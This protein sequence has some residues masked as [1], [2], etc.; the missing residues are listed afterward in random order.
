M[1]EDPVEEPEVFNEGGTKFTVFPIYFVVDVSQSMGRSSGGGESP[2][3]ALNREYGD[4]VRELKRGPRLRQVAQ[5]CIISF[6]ESAHVA[7]PLGDLDDDYEFS[8]DG[9]TRYTR[10]FQLLKTQIA[11]DMKELAAEGRSHYRPTVF[12][13]TDGQPEPE[14]EVTA[15]PKFHASIVDPAFRFHPHIFAFG[16]GTAD[17][18][19]LRR[20]A[21][22][23]GKVFLAEPGRSQSE[24][25]VKIVEQIKYSLLN[26]SEGVLVVEGT[27]GLREIQF[28]DVPD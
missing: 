19:V 10:A 27:P 21:A 25:L 11:S 1:F 14:D 16:F 9:R 13:L 23:N 20:I 3:E 22:G 5:M 17:K 24:G 12:F 8:A 15:W 18:D 7:V 6:S 26:P 28:G 4:L 2:I